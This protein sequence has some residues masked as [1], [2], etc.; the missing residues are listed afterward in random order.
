MSTA[1]NMGHAATAAP[2]APAPSDPTLFMLSSSR[3]NCLHVI[4]HVSTRQRDKLLVFAVVLFHGHKLR[5]VASL[6][7]SYAWLALPETRY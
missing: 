4:P 3:F 1:L 6:G 7:I 5:L 2:M